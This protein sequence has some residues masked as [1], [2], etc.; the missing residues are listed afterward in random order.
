[1]VRKLQGASAWLAA[2]A[3]VLTGLSM[4]VPEAVRADAGCPVAAQYPGAG[5]GGDPFVLS[6]PGHLQHLR[7]TIADWND[8]VALAADIDMG[9]CVWDRPI[10]LGPSRSWDGLMDGRGYVVSGLT[11]HVTA[12]ESGV[13]PRKYYAGLFGYSTGIIRN[14]GF[15]GDVA[16]TATA[17]GAADV[18]AG[19]LVGSAITGWRQSTIEQSYASGAVNVDVA[20][21]AGDDGN[22]TSTLHIGGLAG[23]SSA[24]ISNAYSR[25]SATGTVSLTGP[26]TDPPSGTLTSHYRLGGLVGTQVGG[27]IFASFSANSMNLAQM[28][29]GA[30]NATFAG[31]MGGIAGSK[32][33]GVNQAAV[34]PTGGS[35][36]GGVGDGAATGTVGVP[37]A[38]QKVFAL[39]QAAGWDIGKGYDAGDT[40]GICPGFNDG[41]PYLSAFHTTNPC[42]V[43][44]AGATWVYDDA[45]IQAAVTGAVDDSIICVAA[46]IDL[47]AALTIDDTTLT[48]TGAYPGAALDGRDA[49]RIATVDLRD[50]ADD[51][52]TVRDLIIRDG[53]SPAGADGGCLEAV[54]DGGVT[55]DALVVERSTFEGCTSGRD[56]GAIFGTS[57]PSLLLTDDTFT[58]NVTAAGRSGGAVFATGAGG[59]LRV[60]RS[61]F[62]SN[63]ADSQGGAI[64]SSIPVELRDSTLR[65]NR[66]T[67]SHGG[68]VY[69]TGVLVSDARSSFVSN[70]SGQDGGAIYVAGQ[71]VDVSQST[72]TSNQAGMY[73]GAIATSSDIVAAGARFNLNV[74]LGG[75]GGAVWAN[76]NVRSS[77]SEFD[78]NESRGALSVGGAVYAAGPTAIN[79]LDDSFLGNVATAQGGAI[80]AS[81]L[82]FS[83]LSDFEGNQA[84][85][86]TGDGGAINAGN[87]AWIDGGLFIANTAGRDGGAVSVRADVD[88][89]SAVFRSNT[90]GQDGGAIHSTREVDIDTSTFRENTFVRD[91]GAVRARSLIATRSSFVRNGRDAVFGG[92]S[93]GGGVYVDDSATLTNVTTVF[94]RADIGG[95]LAAGP[96]A[97][98]LSLRFVTSL[99]DFA[100]SGSSIALAGTGTVSLR[101]T[102]LTSASL[103]DRC[104]DA[105]PAP[106]DFTAGSLGSY[107]SDWSCGTGVG[108]IT[109]EPWEGMT[110]TGL[111]TA[112]DT[113]GAQVVFPAGTSVLIN[114][115]P[116]TLVPGVTTDQLG[117]SRAVPMGLTTV[118]AVQ[119]VPVPSFTA[120]PQSM[121]VTTGS[122][123]TFTAV[124]AGGTGP[125][126]YQWERSTD[127]GGSWGAVPGATGTTYSIATTAL[128]DSGLRYR[129]VVTDGNGQ[130]ATSAAATLTVGNPPAPGPGPQ[131]APTPSP[132]P[133]PSP[134]PPSAPSILGVAPGDD[135]ALVEFAAPASDGGAAITR[136]AYSLDDG[137]WVVAS[138]EPAG[139]S[140]VIGGLTPDTAYAVRIQAINSAGAGTPS[141]SVAFTTRAAI[142]PSILIRG[143]RTGDRIVVRGTAAGLAGQAL[144]PWVRL[145]GQ[146]D[147]RPGAV[148]PVVGDDGRFTWKRLTEKRTYVYFAA[149]ELASNRITIPAARGSRR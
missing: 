24:D 103:T 96:N 84:T 42:G 132:T 98:S 40:W 4:V 100:N 125:L 39:Y 110:F 116:S 77:N 139:T 147:H 57:I 129:S 22:A 41:L 133:S 66:A 146:R 97:V 30:A 13:N 53:A 56:G 50:P 38:D 88:V 149:E 108:T 131:P 9:G 51:T 48:L 135:T 18:W 14:L 55:G 34:W 126:T 21:V 73:G 143:S 70:Q 76:D 138:P 27:S 52:V 95:F 91:G 104:F 58:D 92:Q 128:A 23:T 122:T 19:G 75:Q 79:S 33:A 6:T 119:V 72:F 26:G 90:A 106:A 69:A 64:R 123:A 43:C 61:L 109:R 62:A 11:V 16:V 74:S 1:M 5:T 148:R 15:T 63:V 45:D 124:A 113:P 102:V 105:D 82:V 130:S 142:K 29:A 31:F 46:E 54:G 10:G 121:S 86:A 25:A 60:T 8:N 99:D 111:P 87:A 117:A 12:A 2:A 78:R 118:G 134:R 80:Y 127:N 7:D 114:A 101:G 65:L 20:V 81:G 140:M 107:S 120:N 144:T 59:A 83:D 145:K 17:V 3:L 28:G 35:W 94:N 136:Y 71:N 37:A 93:E 47:S 112:D 141:E 36:A 44:P 67:T 32:T 68:A 137:D 85:A 49:R 89:E 115:V